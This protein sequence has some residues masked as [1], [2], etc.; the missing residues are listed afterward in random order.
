MRKLG[1]VIFEFG[2]P[3]SN[4]TESCYPVLNKMYIMLLLSSNDDNNDGIDFPQT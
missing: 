1:D 2:H 4:Q 3:M